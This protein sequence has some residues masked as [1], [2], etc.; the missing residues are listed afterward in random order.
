MLFVAADGRSPASLYPLVVTGVGQAAFRDQAD[1]SLIEQ[2]GKAVGSTLIGQQFDAPKYFWGRPSATSPMPYNAAG[3]E[4]LEPRADQPGA[5]RRGQGPHRAR[6]AP[7]IRATR[8]PVPVDLVTA[9]GS[10]LDPEISPA[11]AAYQVARVAK[12]RELSPD[13][14]R[15]A[16]RRAYER[17][18]V[19]HSRRG[20]RQRAGA[21]SRARRVAT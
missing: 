18:A 17:P 14:V 5:G 9:S 2:D 11:A 13:D 4:R 6:C 20:A 15:C 7:P 21:Q 1:G 19:R 8:R 3:V 12:A 10:G 16:G